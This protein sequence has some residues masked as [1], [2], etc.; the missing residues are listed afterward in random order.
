MP[1]IPAIRRSRIEL[2]DLP[3]GLRAFVVLLAMVVLASWGCSG[4]GSSS[5]AAQDA[6]GPK[7]FEEIMGYDWSVAAGTETYFCIYKTITTDLWINDFRPVFPAGTH[8]VTLGF[9]DPGPADGVV[10][11]TDTTAKPACNGVTLGNNLLYFA[12]VGTGEMALPA[13]VATKVT[14]GKQLVL[15][16]HLFNTTA[17]ELKGHSGVEVVRPDP[18][19]VVH[20]AEVIAA[21]KFQTLT[22]P[23]GPSTQTGTCTMQDNVTLFSV[24]PHMHLMGVHLKTTVASATG[25][26]TTLFDKDYQFEQQPYSLLSPEVPLKKGDQMQVDCTYNNTGMTTL[27]FGE[28]TN[29]NEMCILFTY[30]YPAIATNL[31]C[32]Q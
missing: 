23:P 2:R 8:H 15:S 10:A 6:A 12:G 31:L 29:V 20:Q 28:S 21:G 17:T 11:S 3:R 24:A 25:G 32:G 9:Q 1:C 13:G 14:A 26:V 27:T 7:Q 30:R 16:L 22:V 18:A 19:G 4:N 5:S